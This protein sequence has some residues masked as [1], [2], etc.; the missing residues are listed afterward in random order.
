MKSE[1]RSLPGHWG[2]VFVRGSGGTR[3]WELWSDSLERVFHLKY[4]S[5]QVWNYIISNFYGS[6]ENFFFS[7][8]ISWKNKNGITGDAV[9]RLRMWDVDFGERFQ[10]RSC[11]GEDGKAQIIKSFPSSSAQ[12][13][14][15]WLGLQEER[16]RFV[17]SLVPHFQKVRLSGLGEQGCGD[18]FMVGGWDDHP[19]R[20]FF[21]PCRCCNILI[22]NFCFKYK[23]CV[24]NEEGS[25]RAIKTKHSGPSSIKQ[26]AFLPP[27]RL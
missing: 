10:E 6:F 23:G 1:E 26:N 21:W 16:G 25:R 4:L 15:L 8:I 2:S 9:G 5:P 19:S 20:T 11:E 24:T 17:P 18:C 27:A 7:S 12:G 3:C 13:Q 14:P 22:R